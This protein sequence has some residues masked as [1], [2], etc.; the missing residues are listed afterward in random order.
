MAS[1]EILRSP[2]RTHQQESDRTLYETEIQ[3]KATMRLQLMSIINE[4][5]EKSLDEELPQEERKAMRKEVYRLA[6]NL[7]KLKADIVDLTSDMEAN[8]PFGERNLW[9]AGPPMTVA[10]S[11]QTPNGVSFV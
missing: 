8:R 7:S 1:T 10:A 9:A 2:R 11:P 5:F 6:R 4:K 3:A